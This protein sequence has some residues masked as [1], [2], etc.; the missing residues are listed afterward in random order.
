MTT[1][2]PRARWILSCM[3]TLLMWR[4]FY[5]VQFAWKVSVAS[6]LFEL[7]GILILGSLILFLLKEFPFDRHERFP[8]EQH[9][10]SVKQAA[11]Q[12]SPSACEA[13]PPFTN[14]K[15][16]RPPWKKSL[17]GRAPSAVSTAFS[18][19]I[20]RQASFVSATTNKSRIVTIIQSP[21]SLPIGL[22]VIML[23]LSS[24][25]FIEMNK[26]Q[27]LAVNTGNGTYHW[28]ECDRSLTGGLLRVLN[29][30]DFISVRGKTRLEIEAAG[31]R[32]WYGCPQ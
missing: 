5:P 7:F 11:K 30:K 24:V 23:I 17:R 6:T 22:L 16:S 2:S 32:P 14:I 12:A 18:V 4:C 28:H 3:A 9:E 19:D 27:L 15:T 21:W 31:F 8:L 26:K 29:R 1:P 20:E 25:K 10:K 13:I